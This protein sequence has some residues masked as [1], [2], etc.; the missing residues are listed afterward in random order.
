VVLFAYLDEVVSVSSG[1][2][3]KPAER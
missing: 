1:S 3:E 2:W